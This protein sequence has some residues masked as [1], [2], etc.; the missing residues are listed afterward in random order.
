MVCFIWITVIAGVAVF[1]II[2]LSE[3]SISIESF[4]NLLKW[5]GLFGLLGDDFH[6]AIVHRVSICLSPVSLT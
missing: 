3:K 2:I 6:H 4:D 5:L 1:F